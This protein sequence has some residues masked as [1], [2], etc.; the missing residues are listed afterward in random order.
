MGREE[1]RPRGCSRRSCP[2]FPILRLF[3]HRHMTKR[4]AP[5]DADV[6]PAKAGC[7]VEPDEAVEL[8]HESW[9]Q[10][11]APLPF[12]FHRTVLT[13]VCRTFRDILVEAL[14]QT[15]LPLLP[16]GC[17]D[18]LILQEDWYHTLQALYRQARL[19]R[20]FFV[21]AAADSPQ[22]DSEVFEWLHAQHR[23]LEDL[24]VVEKCDVPLMPHVWSI[25]D[26][27]PKLR[28]LEIWACDL[29]NLE[30]VLYDMPALERLTLV[31]DV[32]DMHSKQDT[33]G[34]AFKTSLNKAVRQLLIYLRLHRQH[35]KHIT[36]DWSR[37]PS[38][39]ARSLR[40]NPDEPEMMSQ[41]TILDIVP[42]LCHLHSL[43][44]RG[45]FPLADDVRWIIA[46]LPL[47]QSFS[48]HSTDGQIYDLDSLRAM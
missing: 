16:R 46:R 25:N 14:D 38:D 42:G 45:F 22:Y 32:A 27:W 11:F 6:P 30:I 23:T 36:L 3:T 13:R 15:E 33:H 43:T 19:R 18:R 28:N 12:T 8:P 2:G 10:I 4:P 17:Y 40:G 37:A 29:A 31:Y 34:D 9:R 26:T 35:I 1:E 5:I 7:L 41:D 24:C 48:W 39:W 47:L 44:L 21:P 20:I